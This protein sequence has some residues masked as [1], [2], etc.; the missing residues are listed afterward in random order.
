MA[1]SNLSWL[2]C[3]LR[4]EQ[5]TLRDTFNIFYNT[6]P[7]IVMLHRGHTYKYAGDPRD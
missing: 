4:N 7:Q 6:T 2:A 3:V 1:V 5:Y